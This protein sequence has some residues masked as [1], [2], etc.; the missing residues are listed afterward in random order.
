MPLQGAASACY[1]Y[2]GGQRTLCE[3]VV[4]YLTGVWVKNET[5]GKVECHQCG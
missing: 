1:C 3:K 5:L 2:M 4:R